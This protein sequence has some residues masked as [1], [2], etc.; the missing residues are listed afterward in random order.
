MSYEAGTYVRSLATTADLNGDGLFDLFTTDTAGNP[1]KLSVLLAEGFYEFG[2]M[3]TTS[4]E[5]AHLPTEQPLALSGFQSVA[6]SPDGNFAYAV[7]PQSNAL[8]SVAIDEEG[9]LSCVESV[10][11][12]NYFNGQL[13]LGLRAAEQVAINP[14][15]DALYVLS[16]TD[17]AVAVFDRNPT[18]GKLTYL[19]KLDVGPGATGLVVSPDGEKVY[20]SGPGVIKTWSRQ[21]GGTLGTDPAD[22]YQII[23]AEDFVVRAATDTRLFLTSQS[24]DTVRVLF[25]NTDGFPEDITGFPQDIIGITDPSSLVPSSDGQ[26]LYITDLSSGGSLHVARLDTYSVVQTLQEDVDGAHGIAGANAV[27]LSPNDYVYVTGRRRRQPSRFPARP[28]GRHTPVRPGLAQLGQ[29]G[30]DVT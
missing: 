9:S 5:D 29:S 1:N 22:E 20:T 6:V 30:P 18:D 12:N 8:V 16:P 15:Y 7:D 10:I 13:V 4:A 24:L 25:V 19:Q 28:D 26:F 14:Q 3:A 27:A 23:D 2:S 11:D 17:E 21:T